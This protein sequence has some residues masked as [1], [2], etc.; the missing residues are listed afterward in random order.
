MPLKI[1]RA[2]VGGSDP[3][4]PTRS[5]QTIRDEFNRQPRL[6]LMESLGTG[7]SIWP[8]EVTYVVTFRARRGGRRLIPV[9]EISSS[10]TR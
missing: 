3:G 6:K 2:E 4:G 5:L 1:L 8:Q 10:R 9:R 7:R